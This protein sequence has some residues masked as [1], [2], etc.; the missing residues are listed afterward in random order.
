MSQTRVLIVDDSALNLELVTDVLEGAGYAVRQARSAEEGLS[1]ARAESPDLILM[2]I[3]LPG[4]D[5]HAAVREL[6]ADPLTRAIPTVAL[7]AFAMAGDEDQ[8]YQSGFDGYIT[9]PIHTRTLT[10]TIER[11]LVAGAKPL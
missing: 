5:G 4:M 2:D 11:L 1:L 3:G 10:Q 9:K 8:A 7:T 6:K